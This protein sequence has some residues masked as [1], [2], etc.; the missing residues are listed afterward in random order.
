[1]NENLTLSTGRTVVHTREPNGATLA[2]PTPGYHA[3]T[4]AE[5]AEYQ[6]V[7]AEMKLNGQPVPTRL[8]AWSN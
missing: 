4:H 6:R 3:F 2:T 1:M 8:I 5:L 7:T